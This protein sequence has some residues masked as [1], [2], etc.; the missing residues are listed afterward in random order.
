MQQSWNELFFEGSL[1]EK[2]L[3]E[4]AIDIAEAMTERPGVSM[5]AA[6]D[7]ANDVRA[8]YDFFK[9]KR[10]SL[11]V[12]LDPAIRTVM[13]GLRE[14]GSDATVLCVQDTTELNHSHRHAMTGLGALG[15]PK[16]R[17][18][19]LHPALAISTEGVPLGLLNA[20]T[21]TRPVEE[22]GKAQQRKERSFEDKESVRWWMTI[23]KV[24]EELQRPGLLLHITDREGDIFELLHRAQQEQKRVLIRASQDRRV[25]GEHRLLWAQ[26]ESFPVCEQHRTIDVPERPAT[27]GKPKRLARKATITLSYGQVTIRAPRGCKLKGTVQAWAILVHELETP[28]GEEPIEWLL[29]TFDQ[30]TSFD[31]A[32]QHVDWYRF[33]WVIEEFF[34]VLKTG[35]KVEKRQFDD[36]KPFEVSLGISLLVAVRLL[37]LT[38][39]AR[40][41]PEQPASTAL[42]SDEERVLVEHA[43]VKRGRPSSSPLTML[44]AVVLIAKLGGYLGRSCDGPPGW[45]TLWRGYTRLCAMV[46][47]YRLAQ[48]EGAD[49]S[50]PKGRVGNSASSKAKA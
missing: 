46:D 15:N 35:L 31:D 42:S 20:M 12:V 34:K 24:E 49:T 28:P 19:F 8:A 43:Q 18:E 47:G 13:F 45:I 17:G 14:L 22:R 16:D 6:F 48:R 9:N 4:R 21:W 27:K 10:M 25:E 50:R 32:W 44:E 23:E 37:A 38:K 3:R 11:P 41:D 5:T 7:D 2:R 36:L 30:I 33:R 29:L 40:I 26:A 39:Q 1:P